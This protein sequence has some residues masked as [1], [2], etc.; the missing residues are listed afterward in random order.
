VNFPENAMSAVECPSCGSRVGDGAAECPRCG[1][2]LAWGPAAGAAAPPPATAA[3]LFGEETGPEAAVPPAGQAYIAASYDA[4]ALRDARE[5]ARNTLIAGVVGLATL[6]VVVKV[7][8]VPEV[9]APDPAS[10]DYASQYA[11]W[12]TGNTVRGAARALSAGLA[13]VLAGFALVRGMTARSA[14]APRGEAGPLRAA[15]AAAIL[16]ALELAALLAAVLAYRPF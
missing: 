1:R 16:G 6:L 10:P 7:F 3:T 12:V 2:R 5:A 11:A 15:T 14:L 8:A 4:E 13:G 9:P